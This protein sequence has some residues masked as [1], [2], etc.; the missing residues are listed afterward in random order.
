MSERDPHL[1]ELEQSFHT[2]ITP[3]VATHVAKQPDKL[4]DIGY[5]PKIKSQRLNE[6][7]TPVRS[8][9]F[10]PTRLK[11]RG[12]KNSLARSMG[13]IDIVE[14]AVDVIRETS[15]ERG[16]TEDFKENLKALLGKNPDMS[17]DEV[18]EILLSK[19]LATGV[20]NDHL[21]DGNYRDA[22]HNL[23][24]VE[25]AIGTNEAREAATIV[26]G[27]NYTRLG[28]RDYP[29]G[30]LKLIAEKLPDAMSIVWVFQNSDSRRGLKLSPEEDQEIDEIINGG[31]EQV[32]KSK[33]GQPQLV[34]VVP[35]GTAMDETNGKL[36]RRDVRPSVRTLMNM[37]ALLPLALKEGQ[38][39]AGPI[40][41]A[42][43]T[44]DETLRR[45]YKKAMV[46]EALRALAV[47]GARVTG[48]AIEYQDITKK[49]QLAVAYPK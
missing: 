7:E 22:A 16:L 34:D 5:N 25:L 23:A 44:S 32:F 41:V 37:D 11:M 42:K 18:L 9:T 14:G 49:G 30:P 8:Y 21:E 35:S 26:M 47:N 28:Y 48:K 46:V 1:L 3:W 6:H 43:L 40:I 10:V 13:S 24:L 39:I 15:A 36:I 17:I 2:A 29:D 19:G 12:I 4:G 33:Q 45:H 31:A 20:M 38:L 27:K